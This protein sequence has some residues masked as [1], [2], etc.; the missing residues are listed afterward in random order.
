MKKQLFLLVLSFLAVN[1]FAQKLD[2][3]FLSDMPG[4][5]VIYSDKDGNRINLVNAQDCFYVRYR[6]AGTEDGI[7]SKISIKKAF[8]TE[9]KFL[10]A[11]EGSKD[12]FESIVKP[13]LVNIFSYTDLGLRENLPSAFISQRNDLNGNLISS[14]VIDFYVPITNL[15]S[16]SDA[17]GTVVIKC[18]RFGSLSPD[19]IGPF[20]N[21][22]ILPAAVIR[23]MN[24][25]KVGK[26]KNTQIGNIEISLP[27][28]FHLEQENCYALS[29]TTKRDS[30]IWSDII[31]LDA[32]QLADFWTY[33]MIELLNVN[34]IVIPDSV[35]IQKMGNSVC[36]IYKVMDYEY[37]ELNTCIVCLLS[38]DG[39]EFNILKINGYSQFIEKNMEMYKKMIESAKIK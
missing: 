17:N 4:A 16:E 5:C 35:E 30:I 25:V 14:A 15:I 20:L 22:D 1:L 10:E 2:T 13:K 9:I 18:D 23:E 7:T 36:L 37:Y 21:S 27:E 39:N 19:E 3:D 38:N 6:P 31:R 29:D 34:A 12:D 32:M 8:Y 33:F 28:N 26:T 11:V 24:T